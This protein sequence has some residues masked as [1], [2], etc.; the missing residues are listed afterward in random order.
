M[1]RPPTAG[2]KRGD[3]PRRW[4]ERASGDERRTIQGRPLLGCQGVNKGPQGFTNSAPEIRPARSASSPQIPVRPSIPAAHVLCGE[5]RAQFALSVYD[6]VGSQL[7]FLPRLPLRRGQSQ[8]AFQ[9]TLQSGF[10]METLFADHSGLRTRTRP[11]DETIMSPGCPSRE[12]V[13]EE[14]AGGTRGNHPAVARIGAS[15][16]RSNA[17][18]LTAG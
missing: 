18:G 15:R 8:S 11:P 5:L 7:H 16:P 12:A 17:I 3:R 2:D 14:H 13:V 1:L 9:V 4:L 6:R 10:P